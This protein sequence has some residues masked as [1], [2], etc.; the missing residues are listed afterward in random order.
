M[1]VLENAPPP[2]DIQQ[3]HFRP[4]SD[5]QLQA[6]F[7]LQDGGYKVYYYINTSLTSIS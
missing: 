5:R 2:T 7:T 6:A 3:I 4:I 1:Q